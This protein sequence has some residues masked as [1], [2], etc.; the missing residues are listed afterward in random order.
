MALTMD[1]LAIGNGIL[2][3]E[4]EAQAIARADPGAGRQG[5]RRG[6]GGAGAAGA[7]VAA[8]AER[9]P[10]LVAAQRAGDHRRIVKGIF[11][12]GLALL[13]APR[14]PAAQAVFLLG[15]QRGRPARPEK[16]TTATLRGRSSTSSTPSGGAGRSSAS[17]PSGMTKRVRQ[18]PSRSSSNIGGSL[19]IGSPASCITGTVIA[20]FLAV[21]R[22]GEDIVG[23]DPE[24]LARAH[25]GAARSTTVSATVIAG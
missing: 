5:R 3:V 8:S 12:L 14:E 17:R 20:Q 2:T 15:K 19:A 16:L 1:G 22:L 24:A 7:Q 6:R 11:G 13:A 23:K 9:Q 18:A 21:A 4:N 10:H 25:R